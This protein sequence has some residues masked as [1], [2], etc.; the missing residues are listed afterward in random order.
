[1]SALA[2]AAPQPQFPRPLF[3]VAHRKLLYYNRELKVGKIF[4]IINFILSHRCE[5]APFVMLFDWF[6]SGRPKGR[7]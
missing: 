7:P 1:M 2:A 3:I 6:L 4:F 5:A